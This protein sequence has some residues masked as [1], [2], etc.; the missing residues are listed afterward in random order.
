MALGKVRRITARSDVASGEGIYRALVPASVYNATTIDMS[1]A[2]AA[3]STSSPAVY[4]FTMPDGRSGTLERVCMILVD[5][6]IDLTKFGGITAR[7]NGLKM[8]TTD[9][10]GDVITNYTTDVTIKKSGDFALFAGPDANTVDVLGAG[11]DAQL[12]RWTF[13]KAGMPIRLNSGESFNIAV[14]DDITSL[15][16]FTAVVHGNY[17]R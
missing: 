5:G 6:A 3:S 8:Y 11:D 4:K 12:V 15:T 14:Q 10:D 16:E 9:K 7:T 1:N 13:A 17:S 2:S